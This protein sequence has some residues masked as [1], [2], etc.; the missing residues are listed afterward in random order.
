MIK[1]DVSC[2]YSAK[3]E[4]ANTLTHGIGT[5]L[6]IV[7]LIFLIHNTSE[8]GEV[9]KVVSFL[10]YGSSLVTLFLAST[11][12]HGV[13]N[14]N[15]KALFKL[16]DH[17]AIYIL[18]AGTYTPLLL[19]SLDKVLGYRMLILIWLIAL[20]GVLFKVKFKHRFKKLSL[21]TYL[22]MGFISLPLIDKLADALSQSGLILLAG[23]GLFYALGVGFYV[24]KRIPFNHAIW[25]LFVLAGA[26]CHFFVVYSLS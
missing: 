13:N 6:S 8:H 26:S 25:H 21:A 18:I 22:G 5:L 1:Q 11:C 12:Y 10:I 9:E 2:S 19:L 7:A 23:G 20:T 3:E 17:C 16:L 4:F 24:N 14:Q 15:L